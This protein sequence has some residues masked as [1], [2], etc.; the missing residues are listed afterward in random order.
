MANPFTMTNI[1]ITRKCNLACDYC[2]IVDDKYQDNPYGK[3]PNEVDVSKW[4]ML[5]EW[6]K[7]YN[8]DAFVIIYG[9]E[10]TIYPQFEELIGYYNL[11]DLSY[12]VITNSIKKN[13]VLDLIR[14]GLLKAISASVDPNIFL[15]NEKEDRLIKSN[16]GLQLLIEAKEINPN[17]DAVA[18]ITLDKTNYKALPKLVDILRKHKIWASVTIYEKAFNKYYDFANSIDKYILTP[19]DIKEL[20]KIYKEVIDKYDNIHTPNALLSILE[21][22]GVVKCD[23]DKSYHTATI[24]PNGDIRLCLRIKGLETP[25]YNIFDLI[26]KGFTLSQVDALIKEAI[27]K[28]MVLACEGC[29]WTCVKMPTTSSVIEIHHKG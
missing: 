22:G 13:Y 27:N 1:L 19:E 14:Q 17:I 23:L 3:I 28:D 7:Q 5:G 26:E 18:E 6:L 2:R 8:P 15:T 20:T 25:K 11:I 12:T 9:G 16:R 10:P 4:Q 29:S 21:A 24:E